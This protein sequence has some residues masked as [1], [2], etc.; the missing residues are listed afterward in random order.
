MP[1]C[2]NHDHNCLPYDD[3]HL[4]KDNSHL[5][6]AMDEYDFERSCDHCC[7]NL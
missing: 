2:C 6:H 3:N 7:Q 1:T 5:C 4:Y